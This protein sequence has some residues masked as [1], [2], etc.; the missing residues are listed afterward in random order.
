MNENKL[1]KRVVL[2]VLIIVG[3]IFLLI[4][5][6]LTT[7]SAGEIGVVTLFGKVQDHTLNP[8]I[9]L[10]NPLNSIH[11]MDV[12]IQ[13]TKAISEAASNDLQKVNTEI[14]LN[15]SLNR[16]MAKNI[17]S[18]LGAD[19]KYIT[20]SIINPAM[21]EAFKQAV[22][23]YSAEQLI[24]KREIVSASIQK[25]LQNRLI[26]YGVI[27]SNISITDFQFSHAFNQA[28]EQKM[29][30]QQNVQTATNKLAEAQVSAK[31]MLITAQAQADSMKTQQQVLT[32]ELLQKMAIEKWDG[33]L[34]TYLGSTMPIMNI[35]GNK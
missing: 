22:A 12:K 3:T 33:Q 28:I 19:N 31:Q 13:T 6:P 23:E 16:E 25:I 1:I 8:G 14:T 34:P 11:K 29:V 35:L 7:I 5:S 20:N 18:T 9:H 32:P 27:I 15:Y 10:I 21:S 26:K 24:T 2:Y 4:F 17:Y 30:A